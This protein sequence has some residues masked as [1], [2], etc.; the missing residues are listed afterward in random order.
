MTRQVPALSAGH[1]SLS[2]EFW[3]SYEIASFEISH[4]DISQDVETNSHSGMSHTANL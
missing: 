2:N 4:D 1:D 3:N